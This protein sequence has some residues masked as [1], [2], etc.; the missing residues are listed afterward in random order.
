[1]EKQGV[2][3]EREKPEVAD[4]CVPI[5][6]ETW[7]DVV[8]TELEKHYWVLKCCVQ[9]E[10][11]SVDAATCAVPIEGGTLAGVLEHLYGQA[12]ERLDVAARGWMGKRL[13]VAVWGRAEARLDDQGLRG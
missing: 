6:G 7:A 2:L 5:E 1:M 11:S 4:R 13:D 9:I 12:G 8:R 3:I 10:E